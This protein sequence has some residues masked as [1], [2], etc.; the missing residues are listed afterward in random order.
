M[1]PESW[2]EIR[3]GRHSILPIR[4]RT[5]LHHFV[6]NSRYGA[7][8]RILILEDNADRRT[9]M[10]EHIADCLPMFGVSFFETSESMIN[11]LKS[12]KW[13]E[14][15]LIS[16]DND[17]DPIQINGR[18]TDAGDGLAVA[19]FLVEFKSMPDTLQVT[20]PPLVIHTTN[21]LAAL[22]MQHLFS[23]AKWRFE[24][25]TPYDG[26]S[27]IGEVWIQKVRAA[28]VENVSDRRTVA[29][30]CIKHGARG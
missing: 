6:L 28:I 24:R 7:C 26:E 22:Q 5:P 18:A 17:L 13:D 4:W 12:A 19:R 11:A 20:M 27:W 15:A 2:M 1:A 21:E 16:L 23:V 29:G 14:I 30:A 3:E 10:L 9:A 25:V 8:M